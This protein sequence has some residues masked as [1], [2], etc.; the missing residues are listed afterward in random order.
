M[1][2]TDDLTIYSG[3]EDSFVQIVL[4]SGKI[5]IFKDKIIVEGTKQYLTTC[6]FWEFIIRDVTF[7]DYFKSKL[8]L[9][10]HLV[11]MKGN[12]ISY[13]LTSRG[14]RKDDWDLINTVFDKYNKMKAFW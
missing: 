6:Q 4:D 7:K 9:N 3:D 12:P 10:N 11:I 5:N 8:I 1:I 2:I 13:Y 14:D